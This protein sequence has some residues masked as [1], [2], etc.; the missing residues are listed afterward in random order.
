MIEFTL[1]VA[2]KV[3]L[4]IFNLLG[5]RVVSVFD[6]N[7]PAGTHAYRFDGR[8]LASGVYFYRLQA[9]SFIKTR[10]MILLR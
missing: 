10:K 5:E 1:P 9:G 2:Q 6:G 8:G 3:S 4:D 7:L